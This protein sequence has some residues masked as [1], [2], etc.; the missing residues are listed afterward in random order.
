M[1]YPV[2]HKRR[3]V[4]PGRQSGRPAQR[5]EAG[6]ALI[7]VLLFIALLSVLVVEF[8]YESEVEASLA[9]NYGSD[10]ES[11]IAAKSA[12]AQ[13]ISLLAEDLLS[14]QL[15]GQPECDST[16]DVWAFGIPFAPLN[17]AMLRATISDE[18]GKINLNALMDT[19]A[20]GAPQVRPE[21][22]QA[23]REFFRLR[24]SDDEESADLIVDSIIDWLDYDEGDE[25]QPQGAENDYY[26]GL[27]NPYACKN[28]PM[29]SIEELLLI[30]GITLEMYY[31]NPKLDPPVLP[32]FEYLTVHGDWQGR[33]NPNTAQP[34][35][36]A[37]VVAGFNGQPPDISMAEQIFEEAR[38]EPFL[39]LG[40]LSQYV[41]QAPARDASKDRGAAADRQERRQTGERASG[42]SAQGM[43]TVNSNVFRVY[44][45]GM[46]EKVQVRIVAYVWRTPLDLSTIGM[47]EAGSANP[48]QA[49]QAAGDP[50][51]GATIPGE[52]FRILGWKVIR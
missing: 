16:F 47:P 24:A 45:D 37:A 30:K 34:E 22:D 7:L 11:Y 23:L 9:T 12:V 18:Y 25:E 28:G 27:E 38:V 51:Q 21:I 20:G 33:I 43:F 31:G 32:L 46:L 44:G 19:S 49:P 50:L 17:D 26:N 48:Q 36:I 35:V 4:R 13:G 29:D 6:A 40:S 39:D 15:D 1:D 52:P 2:P 8:C 41:P 5:R 14:T 10:L 42:N 3:K